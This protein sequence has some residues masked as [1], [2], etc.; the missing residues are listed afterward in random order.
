MRINNRKRNCF[1]EDLFSLSLDCNTDI[2]FARNFITRTFYIETYFMC[3]GGQS[4]GNFFA[5]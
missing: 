1:I 4:I 5:L 2:A 3:K